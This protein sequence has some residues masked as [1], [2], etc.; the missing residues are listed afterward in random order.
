[1]L[2][3]TDHAEL[4]LKVASSNDPSNGKPYL[5]ARSMG[6]PSRVAAV[7]VPIGTWQL[8]TYTYTGSVLTIYL[9]DQVIGTFTGPMNILNIGYNLGF[10]NNTSPEYSRGYQ[11]DLRIFDKALTTEEVS[12]FF[13]R[14]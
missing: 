9:N 5:Y 4:L 2:S 1:M 8:L 14:S 12:A 7:K 3:A 10:G 6:P 11:S 13:Q